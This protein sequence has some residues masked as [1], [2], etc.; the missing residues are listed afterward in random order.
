METTFLATDSWNWGMNATNISVDS[1][2]ER[3]RNSICAT[4]PLTKELLSQCQW[5]LKWDDPPQSHTLCHSLSVEGLGTWITFEACLTDWPEWRCIELRAYLRPLKPS[6]YLRLIKQVSE[7]VMQGS[8]RLSP[9][10]S[11]AEMNPYWVKRDFGQLCKE[12]FDCECFQNPGI[13]SK[14]EHLNILQR[15]FRIGTS[16]LLKTL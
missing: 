2:G 1:L 11:P 16:F 10:W 14:W 8:R 5:N 7:I 3:D 12:Y 6:S 9:L 4:I 15:A 13:G